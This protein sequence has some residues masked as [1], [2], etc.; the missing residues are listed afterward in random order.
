MGA[1]AKY[2]TRRKHLT[3]NVSFGHLK[4]SVR[5]TS[6]FSG[7]NRI[8]QVTKKGLGVKL[9]AIFTLSTSSTSHTAPCFH[10]E[11]LMKSSCLQSLNETLGTIDFFNSYLNTLAFNPCSLH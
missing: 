5:S 11:L 7:S 10:L 8:V 9:L 3:H 6:L 4:Y 2:T 1:E